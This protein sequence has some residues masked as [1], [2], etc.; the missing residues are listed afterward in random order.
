LNFFLTKNLTSLLG[1]LFSVCCLAD[2]ER[3]SCDLN[4]SGMYAEKNKQ[5]E[6]PADDMQDTGR[7]AFTTDDITR[8]TNDR[9]LLATVLYT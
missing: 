1:V 4:V 2:F 5:G 6:E 9:K 7:S 3:Q 8:Q